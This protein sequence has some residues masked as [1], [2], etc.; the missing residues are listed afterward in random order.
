[1]STKTIP[2]NDA[3][4]LERDPSGKFTGRLDWRW[5]LYFEGRDALLTEG[6]VELLASIGESQSRDMVTAQAAEQSL[7]AILLADAARGCCCD[8]INNT[9]TNRDSYPAAQFSRYLYHETDTRLIYFSD[10]TNW[11]YAAGIWRN[12]LANRPSSG[13]ATAWSN[14]NRY[15][16]SFVGAENPLSESGAWGIG[17]G[18]WAD[19]KKNTG[20]Q[21]VTPAASGAAVLLSPAL[22]ANHYS[23]VTWTGVPQAADWPGVNCRLTAGANGSCYLAIQWPAGFVTL[24]NL[25]DTGAL[26][27][28]QLAQVAVTVSAGTNVLRMEADGTAVRVYF[29]SLLIISTTSVLYATGTAGI[30]IFDADGNAN[31]TI[32]AADLGDLYGNYVVGDLASRLGIDYYCILANAN[33]QPPNPTYWYA[34]PALGT[35]DTGL[36]FFATDVSRQFVW[37]GSAWIEDTEVTDTAWN[38]L[39]TALRIV[40]KTSLF[41]SMVAGFGARYLVQLQNIAG[42]LVDAGSFDI[43]W[44]SPAAGV[45]GAAASISLRIT[46][47]ALTRWLVL[48]SQGLFWRTDSSNFFAQ[49]FHAN[50]AARLYTFPDATGNVPALPNAATTETGSGAIVRQVSPTITTPVIG[51]FITSQHNHQN[52]A[53]GGTLD[54]AA[55]AAGTLPVARGGTGITYD[56]VADTIALT[57]QSGDI[58]AANFAN[59][60]APGTYRVSFYLEDTT[61]DVAA[62]AVQLTVAFTDGN[63]A[64]TKTSAAVALTGIG[65]VR[66]SGVF[67]VQLQSGNVTYAVAHTG[68]FGTAKYALYISFERLS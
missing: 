58:A 17:P 30:S 36:R 19:L 52:A 55:I 56:R 64:T 2:P 4:I 47:G 48:G 57:N 8:I 40:H 7:L 44:D 29:Q 12:S 54:A 3:E 27:F 13:G 61:A 34:L 15:T 26:N 53:G 63:G 11:I 33:Q 46:G 42:T 60:V 25:L 24:Y 16:S 21:A 31:P 41:A 59:T 9:R 62:G 68:I 45:E 20:A 65:T 49:L 43:S 10:G 22:S 6:D 35:S 28:N 50:T 66:D 67:F 32:T 51:S 5:R 1:M 38:S 14:Y 23:Q 39:T 18:A 37:N